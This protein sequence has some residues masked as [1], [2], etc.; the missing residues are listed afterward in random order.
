MA[1]HD[2]RNSFGADGVA[3]RDTLL[4]LDA[5]ASNGDEV[6]LPKAGGYPLKLDATAGNIIAFSKSLHIRG[7]GLSPSAAY[8]A[9]EVPAAALVTPY[10]GSI[11]V[12]RNV[13]NFTWENFGIDGQYAASSDAKNVQGLTF[14]LGTGHQIIAPWIVNFRAHMISLQGC[15]C[16]VW[17][18][19]LDSSDTSYS[20]GGGHHGI[21]CDE[22]PATNG[23]HDV[24]IYYGRIKNRIGQAF[25]S[26]K[27]KIRVYGTDVDGPV[28]LG[29]NDSGDTTPFGNHEFKGCTFRGAILLGDTASSPGTCVGAYATFAGNLFDT[30]GVLIIEGSSANVARYGYLGANEVVVTGNRFMGRNSVIENITGV[31]AAGGEVYRNPAFATRNLGVRSVLTRFV[32]AT[33][34]AA[35]EFSGVNA[36]VYPTPYTGTTSISI[37]DTARVGTDELVITA[38]TYTSATTGQMSQSFTKA[39]RIIFEEGVV[40]DGRNLNDVARGMSIAPTTGIVKM[41]GIPT[42]KDINSTATSA[43]GVDINPSAGAEVD[44]DGFIISNVRRDGGSAHYAA[45]MRTRGAGVVRFKW[46]KASGCKNGST[47]NSGDGHAFAFENTGGFYPGLLVLDSN[48]DRGT[49]AR[50]G[51]VSVK[52]GTTNAPQIPALLALNNVRSGGGAGDA[53]V[54]STVT[55]AAGGL[56][57][58]QLTAKG[59]TGGAASVNLIKAANACTVNVDNFAVASDSRGNSAVA[60]SGAV[61][62]SASGVYQGGTGGEARVTYTAGIL[63]SDPLLGATGLP[64][65]GSPAIDAGTRWWSDWQ[66]DA[67]NELW[68]VGKASLGAL[69]STLTGS[70]FVGA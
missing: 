64:T 41:R 30:N 56:T 48:E 40:F 67:A 1:I 42:I 15:Q 58:K 45:A 54:Y 35:N 37:A 59:N 38:G 22:D 21:D 14:L 50:S 18:P 26:E 7:A 20:T 12:A 8:F 16:D 10:A 13:N 5:A 24:R 52:T 32:R 60:A 70:G 43:G 31:T 61:V 53:L 27:G 46:L 68:P 39:G 3:N 62:F 23:P 49:D 9:I 25:K 47:T 19:D 65:A 4:A 34:L 57:V 69:R 51:F 28:A 2:L 44:F 55:T 29:N 11:Q 17:Y 33:A 63:T 66:T 6:W 36:G